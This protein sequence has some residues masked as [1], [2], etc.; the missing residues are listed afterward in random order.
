MKRRLQ[1][2]HAAGFSLIE[3]LI[4]VGIMAT[5]AGAAVATFRSF[6]DEATRTRALHDIEQICLAFNRCSQLESKPPKSMKQLEGRYLQSDTI[7][8]WGQPYSLAWGYAICA[9]ED[10]QRGTEDDIQRSVR[11]HA[12][13]FAE[14]NSLAS[15]IAAKACEA[16][17]TPGSKLTTMADLVVWLEKQPDKIGPPPIDPWGHPYVLDGQ[18]QFIVSRG[19]DGAEETD[20]DIFSPFSK[21]C[22][23][24]VMIPKGEFLMGMN[25]LARCRP[26]HAVYVDA[27]WM[28]AHLVTVKRYK[29]FLDETGRQ[30]PVWWGPQGAV[31]EAFYQGDNPIVNVNWDDAAAYAQWAGKR[32]PTEAEWEKAARGGLE[33]KNF[34]WGD[35]A[36]QGRAWYGQSW[37]SPK[38][39]QVGSFSANGFGLFD[40]AGNVYQWCADWFDPSYFS[41]SPSRNPQ[42][43][44]GGQGRV[45]R[46]FAWNAASPTTGMWRTG[47]PPSEIRSDWNFGFRCAKSIR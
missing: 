41:S 32:L 33:G 25:N 1:W 30:P 27:F 19:E 43:P 15:E 35:D 14:A 6:T 17:S 36:P 11:S 38:T 7:D 10:M 18:K 12:D 42:G 2:R 29:K 37:P 13:S 45:I 47:F 23:P 21:D 39:A 20:D 5:L 22:T 8:P 3:L 31:A 4:V 28:D 40:M 16:F 24:M 34:P 9:G 26:V 44:G 46:G